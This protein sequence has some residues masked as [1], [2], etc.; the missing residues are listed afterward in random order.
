MGRI[1]AFAA[2]LVAVTI[3]LTFAGQPAQTPPTGTEVPISEMRTDSRPAGAPAGRPDAPQR[4]EWEP[5]KRAAE[6]PGPDHETAREMETALATSAGY[7]GPRDE[8][9][10]GL[11]DVFKA[12]VQRQAQLAT[13]N[14]DRWELRNE[15]IYAQHSAYLALIQSQRFH[16][17]T[18]QPMR[19]KPSNTDDAVYHSTNRGGLNVVFELTRDEFPEYFRLKEAEEVARAAAGKR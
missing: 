9:A 2:A 12:S 19:G 5:E 6:Q 16:T 10:R 15:R 1:L 4:A 8:N 11:Y 14:G 7:T 13:E 17:Y 3:Y 18:Y